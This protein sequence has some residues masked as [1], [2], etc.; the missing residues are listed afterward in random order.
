M[1]NQDGYLLLADVKIESTQHCDFGSIPKESVRALFHS[2][3][4]SSWAVSIVLCSERTE[5]FGKWS[6]CLFTLSLE[7][8]NR[9]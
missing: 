8:G 9:S 3:L 4:P 6:R 5:R 2:G 7:D 1:F